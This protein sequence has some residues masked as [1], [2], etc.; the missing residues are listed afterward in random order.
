MQ[1]SALNIGP[2]VKSKSSLLT[3]ITSSRMARFTCGQWRA[4]GKVSGEHD[5]ISMHAGLTG[6]G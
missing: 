6:D 5:K 1:T 3:E 2:E 4:V